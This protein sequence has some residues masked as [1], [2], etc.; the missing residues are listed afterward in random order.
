MALRM[1][2]SS[3]DLSCPRLRSVV[4]VEKSL[5]LL[6]ARAEEDFAMA[7]LLHETPVTDVERIVERLRFSRAE[8]HHVTALVENLP[9]FS[10]VRQMPV[11]ALKRFLRLERFHDHLELARIHRVT[12]DEDLADYQ[13][14]RVKRKEWS[15]TEI[16]PEPLITGDDLIAM[17]FAPGPA[18]KEILTRVED[19]QLEGRLRTREDALDYVK[20][21][22]ARS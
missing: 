3:G 16:W 5:E 10:Q 9:R 12:R 14:V 18:F 13:F 17:G 8:M 20:R 15:E 11:S 6:P 1:S 2:K 22:F 21:E 4:G 7:V 19:E